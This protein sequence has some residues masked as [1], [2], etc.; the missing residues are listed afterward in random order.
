M[1]LDRG[2][3]KKNSAPGFRDPGLSG[4]VTRVNGG[5]AL[6]PENNVV[7]ER[8]ELSAMK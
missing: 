7:I 3:L 6:S 5:L 1:N 4:S 8:N 2:N